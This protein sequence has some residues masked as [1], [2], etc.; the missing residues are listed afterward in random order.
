MGSVL[1]I[2]MNSFKDCFDIFTNPRY[3]KI[4][5]SFQDNV[6]L[7]HKDLSIDL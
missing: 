3:K 1:I 4:Q 5:N 7:I 2:T 6:D